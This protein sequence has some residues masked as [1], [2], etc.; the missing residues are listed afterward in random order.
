MT[1]FRSRLTYANVMATVAVFIAMGGT[2]IAAISLSKNS[3][4]SA[5]IKNGQVKTADLAKNAVTTGKVK[6]R[7]LRSADFA[8]DQ[9]PAGERGPTGPRG[10]S[11]AIFKRNPVFVPVDSTITDVISITLPPGSWVVTAGATLNNNGDQSSRGTCNLTAG[12]E[13]ASTDSFDEVNLNLAATHEPADQIPIAL[14]GA[15][16]VGAD[17]PAVF[18]CLLESN[19]GNAVAPYISAIQV[20]SLT[21]P[22]DEDERAAAGGSSNGR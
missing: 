18:R 11:A 13:I 5:T 7:S 9:L 17:T 3:V 12:R 16:T 1:G 8:P 2:S 14:T 22:S 10:P 21:R 19:S 6:N 15:V 4:K 20:A